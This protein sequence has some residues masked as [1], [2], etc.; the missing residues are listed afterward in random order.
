MA[1]KKTVTAVEIDSA[2][3]GFIE[4]TRHSENN[5]TWLEIRGDTDFPFILESVKDIDK[6]CK[7][8]QECKILL[9]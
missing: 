8:L 3:D 2:H 7:C 5:S 6:L 4:V 9:K 1:I